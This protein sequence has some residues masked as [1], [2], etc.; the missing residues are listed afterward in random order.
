MHF[1]M[2]HASVI[3][4]FIVSVLAVNVVVDSLCLKAKE[5]IDSDGIIDD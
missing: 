1:I 2:A 5:C 3:L 4:S